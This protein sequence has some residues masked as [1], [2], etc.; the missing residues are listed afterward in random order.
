[1]SYRCLI[2]SLACFLVIAG[3]RQPTSS[4]GPTQEGRPKIAVIPKGTTHDFW[5]SVHAGAKAAADEFGVDII[6]KGPT[7]EGRF[8]DQINIVEDMITQRVDGVVLAPTHDEALAD[9]VK[10]CHAKG[11]PISIFDS[12]IKCDPSNYVTFAATDNYKGG[13][14]AARRMAELLGK[15]G[16]VGMVKCQ[17]GGASTMERE[18]GFRDTLKKEFPEMELVDEKWG[19]SL[20]EKS[21]NAAEDILTRAQGTLDGLFGSNESS[22]AGILEALKGR[23]LAGKIK[24][25]GFDTSPDLIAG[26][27][28]GFIHGLVVQNP[29]KMGYEGVKSIVDSRAGKEV[30]KRI[31]TGAAVVTKENMNQPEMQKLINPPKVRPT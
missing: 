3:C 8:A 30:P 29:Y 1:M 6:W 15:K 4:G 25:V 9:V 28:A 7:D 21:V 14:L 13:V 26:M 22:A 24:F 11:I 16:K 20:R 2:G 23:Q 18:A 19:Y 31:D 10:K 17:P 27:Q 5:T 12:G